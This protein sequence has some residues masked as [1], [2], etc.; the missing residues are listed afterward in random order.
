M[1]IGS[2]QWITKMQPRLA[3][4]FIIAVL[5]LS[6][7]VTVAWLVQPNEKTL[8]SLK[9]FSIE[10]LEKLDQLVPSVASQEQSIG[11]YADVLLRQIGRIEVEDFQAAGYANA[12]IRRFILDN[13]KLFSRNRY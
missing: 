2:E 6:S 12:E 5:S 8:E 10:D 1:L 11:N 4:L 9:E 3:T 13:P 7:A